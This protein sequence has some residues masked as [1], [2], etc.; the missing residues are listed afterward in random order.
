MPLELQIAAKQRQ[1]MAIAYGPG[2]GLLSTAF[3][4]WMSGNGIQVNIN[5]E[6]NNVLLILL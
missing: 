3:M 4:L 6:I 2:K 1:V 5:E